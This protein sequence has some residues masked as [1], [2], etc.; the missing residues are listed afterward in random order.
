VF[1]TTPNE[2][3]GEGQDR[4]YFVQLHHGYQYGMIAAATT[5]ETVTLAGRP[6][7]TLTHQD[8]VWVTRT[9]AT[10]D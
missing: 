9:F 4:D 2:S 10:A 6:S 8:T 5:S 7:W 3:S 1:P